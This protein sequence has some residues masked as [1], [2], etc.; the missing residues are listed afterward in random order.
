M[1]LSQAGRVSRPGHGRR[2]GRGIGRSSVRYEVGVF[3]NDDDLAAA[4]GYFVHVFVDAA[5]ERP[6]A[7]P[8][9]PGGSYWPLPFNGN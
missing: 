8:R 1:P 5:T 7:I 4:E 2:P 9:R 3:R 6:L